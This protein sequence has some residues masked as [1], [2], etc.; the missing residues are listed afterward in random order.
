MTFS[1]EALSLF[2]TLDIPLKSRSRMTV[3][4]I[5]DRGPEVHDPSGNARRKLPDK[6]PPLDNDG[7]V[8]L[9]QLPRRSAFLSG[10]TAHIIL[11]FA[12]IGCIQP[13]MRN[14]YT[15][16]MSRCLAPQPVVFN[17]LML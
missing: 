5:N 6:H 15:Q 17:A 9:E 7:L 16:Q 2:D 1:L 8:D 3:R 13:E 12:G 11:I 4:F 10:T 14:L